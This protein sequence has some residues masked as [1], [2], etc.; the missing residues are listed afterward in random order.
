MP[1]IN[2]T[3]YFSQIPTFIE[4][5]E[6]LSDKAI[7]LYGHIYTMWNV[8]GK[9]FMSNAKIAQRLHTST[10]TVKRALDLLESC[11]YIKRKTI[12]DKKS[13]RI[14]GRVIIDPRVGSPVSLGWGQK[15]PQGRVKN[16]PL[17]DK[18]NRSINKSAN[19]NSN[20][21]LAEAKPDYPYQEII[22]YLN[23][24]TGS[25]FKDTPSKTRSL[26]RRIYK[27]GYDINDIKKVIDKKTIEWGSN[28]KM[29]K[30]LRPSTLFSTKFENYLLDQNGG[31]Y[32]RDRND[33]PLDSTKQKYADA[34]EENIK[35]TAEYLKNVDDKDLPF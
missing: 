30:Y 27:D 13:N 15:C 23:Q 2:G 1:E 12:R 16:D 11:G 21:S 5:D 3:R 28:P 9:F 31:F 4:E 8:T 17:I 10:K 24:K 19:S 25:K 35:R 6:R 7:R 20:V 22:Q 33:R 34:M 14:L 29:V 18:Y 32:S 26:I